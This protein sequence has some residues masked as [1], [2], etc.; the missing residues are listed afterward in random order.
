MPEAEV[1]TAARADFH[2]LSNA[3]EIIVQSSYLI[4]TT[5]TDENA[6]RWIAMLKDGVDRAVVSQRALRQSLAQCGLVPP[7]NQ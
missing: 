1:A 5:C 2:A 6:Q 3:L 4:G 7:S